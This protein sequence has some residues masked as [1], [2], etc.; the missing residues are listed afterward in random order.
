MSPTP[1]P[2]TTKIPGGPA[3]ANAVGE[4][5]SASAAQPNKSQKQ[6]TK[7][8]RRELQEKQRAAKAAKAASGQ[9]GPS[10]APA[11]GKTSTGK[12]GQPSAPTSPAQKRG[13]RGGES[14]VQGQGQAKGAVAVSA[15]KSAKDAKVAAAEVAV[16][17]SR[18]LRIFSHFALQKP[19][20][21]VAKGDVHPAIVRLG[22]MFSEFKISGANARCVATLSA[23]K[24]VSCGIDEFL[25]KLT[26]F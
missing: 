18:G 10:N 1:T 5:S 23:F 26:A 3:H 13:T 24:Q 19:A 20:A 17:Q 4:Q 2:P 22:L 7:A 12:Q 6:M 16:G 14:Q 25:R 11:N 21:H 15:S 8:E 9:A